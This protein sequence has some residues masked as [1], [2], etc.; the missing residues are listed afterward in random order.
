MIHPDAGVS[1][2]RVAEDLETVTAPERLPAH[3]ESPV[4]SEP[5]PASDTER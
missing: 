1:V 4:P 2:I 3:L 5:V